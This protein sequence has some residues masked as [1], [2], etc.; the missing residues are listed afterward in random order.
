MYS[1]YYFTKGKKLALLERWSF[2]TGGHLD[3]FHHMS[4]INDQII[5]EQLFVSLSILHL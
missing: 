5:K 2:Y 4:I 3:R 1:V